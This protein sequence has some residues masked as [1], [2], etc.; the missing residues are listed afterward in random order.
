MLNNERVAILCDIG[1]ATSFTGDKH[2]ELKRLIAEGYIQKVGDS[3]E[4]TPKGEKELEDR[5]A[6]LNEA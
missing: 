6:G 4:L 3:H 2:A 5:G 1:Q